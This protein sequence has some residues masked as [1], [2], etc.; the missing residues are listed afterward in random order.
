MIEEASMDEM[1][2]A[3]NNSRYAGDEALHVEF[4]YKARLDPGKTEEKGH[5][6]YKD[7]L[8]A[9][10]TPPGGD[11]VDQPV[12]DITR[13]RFAKRIAQF[14]AMQDRQNTIEGY[15]LDEWP[16]ITRAQAENLKFRKIFTVEQLAETPD[17]NLQ[18]VMGGMGLKQKAKD[19]LEETTGT[20]AQMAAMAARIAELEAQQGVAPPADTSA[21]RRRARK[22][23]P[24]P[25]QATETAEQED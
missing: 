9:R 5:P 4:H 19:Y 21:P 18:D 6:V 22:P 14:E 11:T 7:V 13:K 25:E 3:M 1:N 8:Y 24:E 23:K 2:S 20:A 15:H 10:I 16:A 12:N 17:G